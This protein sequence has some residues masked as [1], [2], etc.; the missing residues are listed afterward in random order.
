MNGRDSVKVAV[1]QKSPKFLNRDVSIDRAVAAILEAGAAGAE[2]IA[3]PEV[4]LAGYP[5]WTEGWD[6][7]ASQFVAAQTIFHDAAILVPSDD[8]DRIGEAA[9]RANANVVMG[10]NEIDPRPGC[11]TIYNTILF[12]NRHGKLM[13]RHR[14]LMPTFMERMY[15]GRGDASDLA[16]FDTDIGRISGL[17]CGENL[18][19]LVRSAII[20]KGADF[21]VACFPGSFSL[22]GPRLQEP[23]AAGNFWGYHAARAHALEAGAF[24]LLASG[25][26]DPADIDPSFP[27]HGNMNIDWANGGSAII[28]PLSLDLA[29]PVFNTQTI[30][31]ADC[32]AVMIKAVKAIVD[33]LGHYSR[34][35]ILRLQIRDGGGGWST[36]PPM[37]REDFTR[38]ADAHEVSVDAVAEAAAAGGLPVD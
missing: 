32:P 22:E 25:I 12:F 11:Q 8:T 3:F 26:Q 31:Y 4:W 19:S 1:V 17:V 9:R 5:F 30:I 10:V 20:G 13:G 21:H 18:M 38:A 2:L 33:S 27:F 23:T 35:D 36:V 6:T 15:W 34:P 7:Q 37:S 24:T 16:T 14:K 29:P 28:A